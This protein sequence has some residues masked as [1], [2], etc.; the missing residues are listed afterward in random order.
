MGGS[1]Y[2][3]HGVGGP[4]ETVKILGCIGGVFKTMRSQFASWGQ[5][6]G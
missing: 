3:T 5:G 6:K 4:M 2:K 1:N